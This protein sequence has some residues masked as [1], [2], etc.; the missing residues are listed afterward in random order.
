MNRGPTIS[1]RC[2]T[3]HHSLI[4]SGWRCSWRWKSRGTRWMRCTGQS[5]RAQPHTD[6]KH[7]LN[8]NL[9]SLSVCMHACMHPSIHSSVFLSV[10]LSVYL[11]INQSIYLF[12]WNRRKHKHTRILHRSFDQSSHMHPSKPTNAACS[13]TSSRVR[14]STCQRTCSRTQSSASQRKKWTK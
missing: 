11:S 14:Q 4:G 6:S 7:C 13:S 2:L 3:Y 10:C 1:Q 12:I 5:T 9:L 8:A